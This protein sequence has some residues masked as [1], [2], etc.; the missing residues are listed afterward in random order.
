MTTFGDYMK[1]LRA[2]VE[3]LKAERR[4]SSLTFKTKTITATAPATLYKTQTGGVIVA[5]YCALIELI[6]TDTD[7][8]LMISYAQPTAPSR[9]NRLI[10]IE[11]WTMPNG[12]PALYLRPSGASADASM[13][14][15]STKQINITVYITATGDFTTANHQIIGSTRI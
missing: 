10:L 2:E 13:A 5:R 1:A 4:R 15:G 3:A 12:N 14:N 9:S 8:R 7:N 6:P 11:P